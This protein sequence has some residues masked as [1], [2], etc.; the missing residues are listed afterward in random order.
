[1][2]KCGYIDFEVLED[3]KIMISMYVGD[4]SSDCGKIPP[5]Y[6]IQCDFTI[7][8]KDTGKKIIINDDVEC[9]KCFKHYE[10]QLWLLEK[11]LELTPK[12]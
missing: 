8:G 5:R 10:E 2:Y 12:T 9:R 3:K 11:I 7:N 1:M 4:E 6:P